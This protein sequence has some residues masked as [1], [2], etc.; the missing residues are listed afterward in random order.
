MAKVMPLE[1]QN[2]KEKALTFTLGQV[3]VK[4]EFEFFPEQ[5]TEV[6]GLDQRKWSASVSKLYR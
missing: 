2:L 5:L 4:T 3:S 1:S 6:P